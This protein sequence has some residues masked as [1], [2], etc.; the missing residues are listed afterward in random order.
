MALQAAV[1]VWRAL[2]SA[3]DPVAEK[4][5]GVVSPV[6]RDHGSLEHLVPLSLLLVLVH[7]RVFLEVR[8]AQEQFA[9]PS[10]VGLPRVETEGHAGMVWHVREGYSQEAGKAGTENRQII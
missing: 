3:L 10:L 1:P 2:R 6:L 7:T 4:R 9:N 5:C 8:I